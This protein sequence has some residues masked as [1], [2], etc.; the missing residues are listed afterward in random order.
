MGGVRQQFSTAAEV[1]L[2]QAS[3]PLLRGARRAVL[4]P[5]RLPLPRDDRGGARRARGAA[6]AAGGAR[7]AGRA[8]ST[9]RTSQGLRT[10]DVLG[11][12]VCCEDGVADPPA[13][14]RELVRRAAGSAWR[15][16]SARDARDARG[17]HARDRLRAV[18]GRGGRDPRRR[19][20]GAARSA[21]SSLATGRARA[22]PS[23]LPMVIEAETGF[24]FRRRGEP[25]RA[26]DDRA[27]SRAG[28]STRSS[29]RRSSTTG[30]SGCAHRYPPAA[31]ATI[32]RAW[33][34]LYDMT[35]DAHPIIGRVADGV[36]AACGF[37]RP[38]LHAVAGRR[39]GAGGGAPRREPTFD[40]APYRLER[41]AG[42]A[43]FPET[44]VL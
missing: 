3:D 39:R 40:L 14:T 27:R 2:A 15:C 26:R 7:R 42:G 29:T 17:R 12:V 31:E 19:A 22:C 30:A 18:V 36:Y 44:L 25:A 35:P 5:G 20:A 6:R 41:F 24:H 43:S 34:G 4:R 16:A 21:A 13:V 9:R 1:R 37:S 28:A 33:A 10:D 11:A 38:R 23:D 32:E 8:A